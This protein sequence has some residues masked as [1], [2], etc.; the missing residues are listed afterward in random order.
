[1]T[2]AVPYVRIFGRSSSHFTRCVRI[3]AHEL[4]VPYQLQPI[5]DLLSQERADYGGNPALKLPA[6]ETESGSWYGASNICRE[7]SRRAQREVEIVWP[8]DIR[9]STAANAQ[10][11]VLQGMSTEV[12]LVMSAL[13]NAANTTPY[14]AKNRAGLENIL[15][16]LDEQLP[17]AL[18]Q[19]RTERALSFFEVTLFCFVTH[20]IFRSVLD[21]AR[22]ARLRAFCAQ[23]EERESARSTAYKFDVT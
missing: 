5:F 1:V 11:L 9:D 6:L 23:F 10:E 22:F 8:E 7:L 21:T 12:T 17:H 16:W 20:L 18:G 2:A 14:E 3:F 15:I 4:G 13:G 19:L